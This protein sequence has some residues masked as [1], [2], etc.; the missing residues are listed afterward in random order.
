M[1]FYHMNVHTL[2]L[3]LPSYE[4]PHRKHQN[5]PFFSLKSKRNLFFSK[6]SNCKTE[7]ASYYLNAEPRTLV[8]GKGLEPLIYWFKASCPTARPSH[9]DACKTIRL[10]A[11]YGKIIRY[12]YP[13]NYPNVKISLVTLDNTVTVLCH[14]LNVLGHS[15]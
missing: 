6:G 13:W 10:H 3:V 1:R 8:V 4:N 12:P 9:R 11:H 14:L 5:R 15:R 7:R 2:N